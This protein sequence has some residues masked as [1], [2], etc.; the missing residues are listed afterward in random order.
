MF[1]QTIYAGWKINTMEI[2]AKRLRE[3]RLEAKLSARQVG[4][5]IGVAHSTIIRWEHGSRVPDAL[6]LIALARFFNVSTDY[7]CGLEN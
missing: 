5:G 6:D 7:L 4:A 3:L 1:Q 2:F